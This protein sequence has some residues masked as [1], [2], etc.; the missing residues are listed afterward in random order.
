M[1]MD[2][3]TLLHHEDK[4]FLDTLSR[5][6]EERLEQDTI[7]IDLIC[8][9]LNINKVTLCRKIKKLSGQTLSNYIKSIKLRKATYLLKSTRMSVKEIMYSCG[10]NH[11]SLFYKHFEQT[12]GTTPKEWRES[13]F[14]QR[15]EAV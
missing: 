3:G 1:D 2:K 12:Y 13:L 14:R 7:S 11:K 8:K 15:Q 5:M 10:Y 4:I 9:E 6:I